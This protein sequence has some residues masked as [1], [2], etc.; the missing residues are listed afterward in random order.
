MKSADLRERFQSI[1]QVG[2]FSLI[3]VSQRSNDALG[4]LDALGGT[5]LRFERMAN[6]CREV[7][8]KL[9]R[10]FSAGHSGRLRSNIMRYGESIGKLLRQ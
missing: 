10:F 2:C 4:E 5:V 6:D 9:R 8:G 3:V 1:R 7:S